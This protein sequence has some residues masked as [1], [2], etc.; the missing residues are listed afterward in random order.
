[1]NL[2]LLALSMLGQGDPPP[3]PPPL[4]CGYIG[5]SDG[6]VFEP[7]QGV[8]AYRFKI[9]LHFNR[10]PT[11]WPQ[12][13]EGWS[14]IYYDGTYNSSLLQDPEIAEAIA[15]RMSRYG[16]T[17]VKDQGTR[18][19]HNELK[20]TL[21]GPGWTDIESRQGYW[22]IIEHLESEKEKADEWYEEETE[23]FAYE[24]CVQSWNDDFTDLTNSPIQP[25]DAMPDEDVPDGG[26]L[27]KLTD[28]WDELKMPTEVDTGILPSV[29]SWVVP[30]RDAEI[31]TQWAFTIGEWQTQFTLWDEGVWSKLY[32]YRNLVRT[33]IS[34]GFIYLFIRAI[35]RELVGA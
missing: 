31:Q 23:P 29:G 18:C 21:Y 25:G 20:S 4:R 30:W 5:F 19:W 1:M 6:E 13:T 16:L 24:S 9:E 28:L 34:L 8:V 35:W 22:E 32:E 17:L 27:E 26:F 3:D 11:N 15:W 14:Y 7:S 33:V 2:I 10:A 12:E